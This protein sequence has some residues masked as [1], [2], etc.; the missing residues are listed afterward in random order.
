MNNEYPGAKHFSNKSNETDESNIKY[1]YAKKEPESGA[2]CKITRCRR[3]QYTT[4]DKWTPDTMELW[5][6]MLDDSVMQGFRAL[7]DGKFCRINNCRWIDKSCQ[8]NIEHSEDGGGI[9]MNNK[10]PGVT[11]LFKKV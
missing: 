9:T 6:P 8:T 4:P 5:Q 3:I 10:C 1:V 2:T 7:K 11:R